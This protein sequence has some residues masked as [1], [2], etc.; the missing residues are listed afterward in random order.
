MSWKN[1]DYTLNS[2][3]LRESAKAAEWWADA[4]RRAF[5]N[6]EDMPH[7][8]PY[9]PEYF[10]SDEDFEAFESDCK[11]AFNWDRE[12]TRREWAEKTIDGSAKDFADAIMLCD[13]D[14]IPVWASAMYREWETHVGT[15]KTKDWSFAPVDILRIAKI[16]ATG[17]EPTLEDV[18]FV[19]SVAV[20]L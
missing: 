20:N 9:M 16:Y 1:G 8:S 10:E 18:A 13:V 5:A 4:A 6:R 12:V 14:H 11:N 3:G 19:G 17:R 2:R 7:Q 15:E